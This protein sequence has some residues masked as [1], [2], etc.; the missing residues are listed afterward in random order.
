[1]ASP[2]RPRYIRR[3]YLDGLCKS[4][5]VRGVQGWARR[6]S[7]VMYLNPV[8]PCILGGLSDRYQRLHIAVCH[9]LGP[10][11]AYHMITLGPVPKRYFDPLGVWLW[12]LSSTAD[13]LHLPAAQADAVP[14]PQHMVRHLSVS[15]SQERPRHDPKGSCSCM[16][17][18]AT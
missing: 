18:I 9:I 11:T 10:E 13:Y 8:A 4:D 16:V 2:L 17:Y 5:V 14:E 1:M 12:A 6:F 7:I 3:T 15:R